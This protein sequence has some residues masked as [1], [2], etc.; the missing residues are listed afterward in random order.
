MTLNCLIWILIC[1]V[2][3]ISSSLGEMEIVD[4]TSEHLPLNRNRRSTNH[5]ISYFYYQSGEYPR[6]CQEVFDQCEG[7]SLD[8]GVYLIQPV[9]AKEPFEVL[10]NNSIDEGRWTVLQRRMDGSIDFY[11]YWDEYK[12]GFGFL[13]TEFWLGNDKIA[14]LTNQKNYELRIDITDRHGSSYFA[15]YNLFRISDEQSK[16]RLVNIDGYDST[17]SVG[18]DRMS[19]H[20]NKLFSTRDQDNDGWSDYHCAEKHVGAWWFGHYYYQP[21]STTCA[22][23]YY[24]EFFPVGGGGC[25]QCGPFHS[26]GDYDGSTR[27]TNMFWD[28][29]RDG[30]NNDCGLM[31]TD[32][33]IRPTS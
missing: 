29:L 17:S 27:G 20:K 18:I 4:V 26:N 16:Y 31:Y 21:S 23:D 15:K 6:D 1:F 30:R 32:L 8:S 33:K 22:N 9:G 7:D 3:T 19:W 24:C 2:A 25:V 10:C 28:D 5:D 14:L 11:R 12:N 13:N